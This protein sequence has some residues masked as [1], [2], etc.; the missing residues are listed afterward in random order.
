MAAIQQVMPRI[1]RKH[2]AHRWE[3]ICQNIIGQHL[4][5]SIRAV[6]FRA[7]HDIF[8]T[9]E[10]QYSI[11]LR[12]IP[13]CLVCNQKDTILHRVTSCIGARDIWYWTRFRI[14]MM[15]RVNPQHVPFTW[16]LFPAMHIWP[17][18]RHNA[19]IWVLGHMISF[20]LQEHPKL[21]L[22]DYIDFLR[23]SR[24]K[25][26]RWSQRTKVYGNYLDVL[27]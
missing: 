3:R 4:S 15:L 10:R 14:A 23:R 1:Q 18:P 24:W 20:S 11:G 5:T 19:I 26:D 8:P 17:P 25:M 9:N 2:P 22:Q 21:D 16:L 7:V 6:W 27:A 12:D 13:M